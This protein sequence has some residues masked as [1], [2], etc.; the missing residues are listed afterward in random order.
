V[1]ISHILV[2]HSRPAY[3]T[4]HCVEWTKRLGIQVFYV[5]EL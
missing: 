4:S 2:D 3:Q 5:V 1:E